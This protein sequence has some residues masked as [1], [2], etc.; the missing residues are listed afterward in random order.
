MRLWEFETEVPRNKRGAKLLRSMTGLAKL[1]LEEMP[2][3]DIAC[4]DGVRNV[5]QRL[6][7]FFLPHLEVSLP[8]ALGTAVYGAHRSSTLLAWR[9]PFPGY[10]RK[11]LTYQKVLR[12]TFCIDMPQ[13]NQRLLV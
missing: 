7:D 9:R 11:E 13:L 12:D 4:E 3:E 6:K 1:A 10:L 2:F 8:R 5:M